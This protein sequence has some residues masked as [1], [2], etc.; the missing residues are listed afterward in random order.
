MLTMATVVKCSRLSS[1]C[2]SFSRSW[3]VRASDCEKHTSGEQELWL[4]RGQQAGQL[5]LVLIS[6]FAMRY[7]I[8]HIKPGLGP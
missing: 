4:C 2:W 6:T 5:L 3:Y 8:M 1:S 7:R